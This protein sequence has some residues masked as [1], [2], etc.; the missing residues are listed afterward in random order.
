VSYK[1]ISK[2]LVERLKHHLPSI[3]SENQAAFIGGRNIMDNVIIANEMLHSLKKGN[4][5]L[6]PI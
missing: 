6:I 1:I 3:I 5:G 4:V 2:I